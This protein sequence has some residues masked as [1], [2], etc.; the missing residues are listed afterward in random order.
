[1]V[2]GEAA[3][4][5]LAS[6]SLELLGAGRLLADA[7]GQPLSILM[8]GD[9]LAAIGQEAIACGAD[10][11]YLAE[12][13]E[14]RD[15]SSEAYTAVVEK[16][17]AETGP[18]I[19]LLGHTD[20]GIDIAPRLA[21]RLRGG[22]SMD[23]VGLGIDPATKLLLATRPVFGGNAHATF[24]CRQARPQMATLRPHALP[25]AVPDGS[26]RGEV[27]PLAV[28]L[29]PAAFKAKTL[30]R[31]QEEAIGVKLE[32][33]R[34]VVTGGYGVGSMDNF[35]RIQDLARLLGGAVGGTRPVV[36]QGWLP[37][38]ALVG[39]TGKI[40]SPDLYLAVGV[41]GAVQHMA[42]CGS[43]KFIVAINKDAE[44]PIFRVSHFGVVADCNEFIPRLIDGLKAGTT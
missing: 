1:M 31:V 22:L 43:S 39:Q 12:T 26:R 10:K 9:G 34:T 17:C 8:M 38:T 7:L 37:P 28:S 18:S 40:V 42:G 36:E 25:Q 14:L 5:R 2:L 29:D 4:G 41:S 6:I 32:E 15:Y 35:S 33:A 13:P 20:M 16:L 3:G 19:L 11:V 27:V 44:A 24:V 23:C 21:A 30:R